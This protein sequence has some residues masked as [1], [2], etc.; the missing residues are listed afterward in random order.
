MRHIAAMDDGKIP[1]ND[2]FNFG[3][4]AKKD[5]AKWHRLHQ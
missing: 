1:R 3:T 2:G 5:V 4:R